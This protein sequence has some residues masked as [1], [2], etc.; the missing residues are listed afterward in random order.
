MKSLS[1]DL[2]GAADG[3][4]LPL[5]VTLAYV[6][7]A[8]APDWTSIVEYVC[9]LFSPLD[10]SYVWDA[11]STCEFLAWLA[12]LYDKRLYIRMTRLVFDCLDR[13]GTRGPRCS[14][15]SVTL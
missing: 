12:L 11:C 13:K 9:W 10:I 14:I 15:A 4:I 5:S 7:G 2:A 6:A 3:L 8:L 1:L